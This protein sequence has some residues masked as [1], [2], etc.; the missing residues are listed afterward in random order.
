MAIIKD[1]NQNWPMTRRRRPN[2]VRGVCWWA[3]AE[4]RKREF[5]DSSSVKVLSRWFGF[6]RCPWWP[7][8]TAAA[9]YHKWP[10]A[11]ILVHHM[12][13]IKQIPVLSVTSQHHS[14]GCGKAK[15]FSV[16]ETLSFVFLSPVTGQMKQKATVCRRCRC[17]RTAALV[18]VDLQDELLFTERGWCH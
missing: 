13:H 6:F 17:S 5:P 15:R 10:T 1:E 14:D 9:F 7:R 2:H 4:I 12:T 18:V 16:I 11:P 3:C 8:V